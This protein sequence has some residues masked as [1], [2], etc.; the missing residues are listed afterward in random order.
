MLEKIVTIEIETFGKVNKATGK[1]I[2]EDDRIFNLEN[3]EVVRSNNTK[4][5]WNTYRIPKNLIT[6]LSEK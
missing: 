3:V 5:H 1:V 2:Y 6:K 4:E